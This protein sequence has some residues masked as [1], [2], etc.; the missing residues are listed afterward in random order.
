MSLTSG[1]PAWAKPSRVTAYV[2]IG[3]GLLSLLFIP[4][5]ASEGSVDSWLVRMRGG[6][7][8][9]QQSKNP[10]DLLGWDSSGNNAISVAAL[11]VKQ[12]APGAIVTVAGYGIVASILKHFGM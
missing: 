6:Y 1:L 3:S 9:Y 11:Q 4:L 2:G 10:F 8:T 7:E 12:N 5:P